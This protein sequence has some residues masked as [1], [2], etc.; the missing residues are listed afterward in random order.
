M[1]GS[2]KSGGGGST[3]RFNYHAA[4]AVLIC[5][6]KTARLK[7][8]EVRD[9]WEWTGLLSE[10]TSPNPVRITVPKYGNVLFYWGR[11]DQETP[12]HVLQAANNGLGHDHPAYTSCTYLVCEDGFLL[13]L[14]VKNQPK[15]RVHIEREPQQSLINGPAAGLIDGQANPFAIMAEWYTNRR[16]GR[17]LPISLFAASTW[18]AAADKAYANAA[19]TYVSVLLSESSSGKAESQ[20]LMALCDGFVRQQDG[21]GLAEAGIFTPVEE[22]DAESLPVIDQH[23]W[24]DDPDWDDETWSD[25]YSRVVVSYR[26]RN[27]NFKMRSVR[28]DDP[29]ARGQVGLR[30]KTIKAEHIVRSGQALAYAQR[31]GSRLAIP[32]AEGKLTVRPEKALN[33]RP[34]QH[35]RVDIDAEPGG[36]ERRKVCR[37]TKITRTVGRDTVLE[38]ETERQTDAVLFIPGT[39]APDTPPA[40]VIPEVGHL[41]F[42]EAPHL[43]ADNQPYRIGVLASRPDGMVTSFRVHYDNQSGGDF[44]SM[45]NSRSYALR[46]RLNTAYADTATGALSVEIL[47]AINR[48]I[49]GDNPGATAARDDTLLMVVMKIA[50]SGQIAADAQDKA[51]IEIFSVE[52]IVAATTNVVDVTALRGR[53]GTPQRSF[54]ENAEVWFIPRAALTILEHADFP[55]LAASGDPAYFKLQPSGTLGERPIED[56][57]QRSFNFALDRELPPTVIDDGVT[58]DPVSAVT[59]TPGF[60]SIWLNFTLPENTDIRSIRIY[61]GLTTT[62]PATPSLYV[63]GLQNWALR[64]GLPDGVTRH[65]WLEVEATNG[66]VSP[67]VGPYSATTPAVSLAG[68]EATLDALEVK[69]DEKI[70]RGP[71][72]PSSPTLN[73]LWFDT[74]AGRFKVY[75]GTAWQDAKDQ[76]LTVVESAVATAQSTANAAA[77]AA[78]AAHTA[79]DGAATSA[80][81]A[82]NTAST[83]LTN[84]ANAQSTANAAS[85]AASNAQSTA[86]AAN[87]AASNAQSTANSASTAAAAAN[88][89]LADIASDSLLTPDE[90]PR[91]IQ[92]RDVIVAEQSGIDAKA[93]TYGVTTERTAYNNA[94]SALT[95]YLASLTSPVLWSNLAG[96]T[97]IVG[98]TFRSKF[99]DVYTTRQALLNR[100]YQAAKDLADTAQVAANNAGTAAAAA[101]STANAAST[102]ASTAQTT[103]NGAATAATTAQNTA[104]TALT[105]AAGAQTTANAASTAASN[106]QTTANGASTAASNAQNTA[107]TAITNA[108]GAQST[109]NAASTAASNAQTSAN[110]AQATANT[111][112]TA[113]S[114]AQSTANTAATT[115][116]AAVTAAATAQSG[117]NNLAAEYVLQVVT[118]VGGNRRLTGFRVTNQGGASGS[119]EM[120]FQ[121]DRFKFVT[122][123]GAGMVS[124]FYVEGGVVFINTA[125]FKTAA[126]TSAMIQN[127]TA[128]KLGAG[129]ITASVSMTSA[130][131][132]T[133]KLAGNVQIF[134]PDDET[135]LFPTV[136]HTDGVR[137]SSGNES[138][139]LYINETVQENPAHGGLGTVVTSND[140]I[141]EGWL[142]GSTGFDSKRFGNGSLKADISIS[143]WG[144][145]Q[146]GSRA[147]IACA[148]CYRTRDNGGGWGGWNI[149]QFWD[150]VPNLPVSSGGFNLSA[151]LNG[152][153]LTGT[154]SL[155]FGIHFEMIGPGHPPYEEYGCIDGYY[156][157]ENNWVCTQEGWYTVPGSGAQFRWHYLIGS[158]RVF[159]F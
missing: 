3:P 114:N 93:V 132:S 71:T 157:E 116:S 58:P 104:N 148:A 57:A 145:W 141:F 73:A 123:T 38:V 53:L 66:R 94:V 112:V 70:Y 2:A 142:R 39:P 81:T 24:T 96:N 152:V 5:G 65:Y 128:D 137:F 105:N 74:T 121:A 46:G 125:V 147:D 133:S 155:Q 67:I 83:A 43:L 25:V 118:D 56:C 159:N 18:Q 91:V 76:R 86:N 33:L 92:D 61:E 68:I 51:W 45:G 31:I 47:D 6:G 84:A 88:T 80:T 115:A 111:A 1:G 131:I 117:V 130:K 134:H 34:G 136:S 60:N 4:G 113:A 156:D 72:A 127:L 23:W 153:S 52:E 106:A 14:E 32:G 110:G 48:E 95:T 63:S 107:N 12:A 151:P 37:I 150:G 20:K 8:I 42:F 103:A 158:A 30:V 27:K 41:R 59:I 64:Q 122:D 124:P 55:A 87:T 99:A 35:V 101:Q 109:A 7:G 50:G 28:Y 138:A 10:A 75:D 13:G 49:I 9:E 120:V 119:T 69:I 77:T 82:Q 29:A 90:K 40:V 15:I 11:D 144:F 129:T 146:N 44:P 62:R 98:A 89:A 126:I 78:S 149:L 79:A 21:T 154:Q 26:D 108:A 97:T 36:A 17:G 100:I 54:L 140:W 19:A 85:T 139:I 143:G 102:A 16:L 135:R 22:I